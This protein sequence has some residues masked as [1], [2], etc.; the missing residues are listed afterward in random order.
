MAQQVRRKGR[1]KNFNDSASAT[2]IQSLD[3]ALD[4][5]DELSAAKGLT[6][7]ELADALQ[8]SPATLYRILTTFEARGFV[9]TDQV[10]QT[11]HV[12]AAA[13][14]IGSSFLRRSSVLE[15]S[16]PEMHKLMTA[17]GETANLGIERSGQVLFISQ[18]ETSEAIRAFFP[19]GTISPMYASG[20][21]KALLSCF[22]AVKLGRY[23]RQNELNSFTPRSIIDEAQLKRDLDET[24]QRGW[25]FDNE[26]K[27]T[28]MRCVA[29][30]IFD[31]QNNA[32]AGISISGPTSRMTDDR[33]AEF[34]EAVREA[35]DR[36]SIGLGARSG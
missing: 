4:V 16:L 34:G 30:P 23:F 36:I 19:P 28:G 17:T 21:G 29:S 14:R 26:E 10:S 6:L 32:V 25:A 9:E 15:R 7:T 12:G 31:M 22:D 2:R 8:Q 24:Q 27:T 13:F 35:A 20:I 18:V 33:I 5:L 3:R 1:P 11:W